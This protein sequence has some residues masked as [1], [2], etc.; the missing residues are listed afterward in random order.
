MDPERPELAIDIRVEDDRVVERLSARRVCEGCGAITNLKWMESAGNGACGECG[1]RLIVR[2][3]DRPEVI[4]K[5]LKVY[6]E[7]TEPLIEYY[8]KRSVYRSVD[9]SGSVEQVSDEVLDI[10]ED[11]GRA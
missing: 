3:D 8:R 11:G 9:G 4:R 10:V 1:G 2:D 6:H 5:R 7:L